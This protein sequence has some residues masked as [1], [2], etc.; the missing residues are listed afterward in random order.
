MNPIHRT[1]LAAAVVLLAVPLLPAQASE[2]AI[3]KQFDK[4]R[5]LPVEQRSEGILKLA[6]DI[7]TLPAS[8]DKVDYADD[9]AHLA[10]AGDQGA[11]AL[12]AV[13]DTLSQALE[14]SPVKSR[15]DQPP[16]QLLD[17]ARLVRY[18]N[19]TATLNDPLFAKAGQILADYDAD[20]QK[21][22]FT[23]QDLRGKKVTLSELRG[24]IVLINFWAIGCKACEQEMPN[25][26]VIYTHYQSQGLVFLSIINDA[27]FRVSRYL[28]SLEYHYNP[29]ILIDTNGTVA[30]QFHIA[31]SDNSPVLIGSSGK[32][33]KGGKSSNLIQN[34]DASGVPRTFVFDREGKLA[35]QAINQSTQ[36]QFFGMLAAAGL[37]P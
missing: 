13:A 17:L 8:K 5:S 11:G 18:E 31:T 36:R 14:Q 34:V 15:N 12:Q 23:L 35:A 26:D 20:V 2:S 24:K 22:D 3:N 25:L 30:N 21:A 9:L 6:A 28:N 27:P 4:L 37:H 29:T 33:G 32:S 7:R 10:T 1:L 16:M 19:V